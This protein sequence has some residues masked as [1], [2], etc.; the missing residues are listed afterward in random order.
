MLRPFNGS[1]W[2]SLV[3][4]TLPLKLQTKRFLQHHA[5]LSCGHLDDLGGREP[6]ESVSFSVS[7][8]F[9]TRLERG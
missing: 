1:C 7:V 8:W 3:S 9:T 4:M 6:T 2:I 5:F